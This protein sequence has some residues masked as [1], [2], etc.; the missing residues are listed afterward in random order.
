MKY[1]EIPDKIKEIVSY[2]SHTFSST[3]MEKKDIKQDLWVLYLE[4]MADKKNKNKKPGWFFLKFKWFLLNRYRKEVRRINN[5]WKI[6]DMLSMH[7]ATH[8][9]KKKKFGEE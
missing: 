2:L 1:S 9:K 4:M 3:I 7:D 5:E 8:G 6:I